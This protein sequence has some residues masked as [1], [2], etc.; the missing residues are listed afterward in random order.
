MKTM[1]FVRITVIVITVALA[2]VSADARDVEIHPR[3]SGK[4]VMNSS[5]AAELAL[6]YLEVADAAYNPNKK[7]S[8]GWKRIENG[9]L[10]RTRG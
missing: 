7:L 6:K 3:Q 1:Q 10:K 8:E 4:A 2:C 9:L 5:D